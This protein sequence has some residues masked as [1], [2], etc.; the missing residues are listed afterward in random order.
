ML[1]LGSCGEG[2]SGPPP[3]APT[4]S[5]PSPAIA[6]PP[7]PEAAAPRAAPPEPVELLHA[8]PSQVVVSS[9]ASAVLHTAE[10]VDGSMETAWNSEQDD[11]TRSWVAFRLPADARVTSLRMTA[12]FVRVDGSRDFF[13]GN[14]RVRKVRVSRDGEPLG[15]HALDPEDRGLQTIPVAGPGGEWRIDFLEQVP[16][17]SQRWRQTC[18]SELQ[19]LGLPGAER[20]A[21]PTQP[22]V[23]IGSFAGVPAADGKVPPRL[24]ARGMT[25]E[26]RPALDHRELARTLQGN[27]LTGV[28]PRAWA[29]L[30]AESGD[31][32]ALVWLTHHAGSETGA[33]R[34]RTKRGLGRL[35][36]GSEGCADGSCPELYVARV[37]LPA[38]GVPQV[39]RVEQVGEDMCGADVYQEQVMGH[40]DPGSNFAARIELLDLDGVDGLEARCRVRWQTTP[41]CPVGYSEYRR[42]LILDLDSSQVQLEQTLHYLGGGIAGERHETRLAP[43]DVNGDGH[44]DFEATSTSYVACLREDD[45]GCHAGYRTERTT[46]LYDAATDRWLE[47]PTPAP[48]APGAAPP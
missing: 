29:V 6:A 28:E 33:Q 2:A 22:A 8:V 13:T 48:A 31:R 19:V 46:L 39:E 45:Q 30:R 7:G 3:R 5:A 20:H 14:Y 35:P 16:G 18:V 32:V 27:W 34:R 42:E 37:S 9:I 25:L 40:A 24:S 15:E 36:A 43:R 47:A 4:R 23:R 38:R 1:L 11:V 17:T 44:P 10:L 21:T 26:K 41:V 12:G